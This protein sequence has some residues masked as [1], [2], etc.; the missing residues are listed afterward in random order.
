MKKKGK[1]KQNYIE[2]FG[3]RFCL[4]KGFRKMLNNNHPELKDEKL[5]SEDWSKVNKTLKKL[6][7]LKT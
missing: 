6:G 1:F 2:I 7:K 4:P 3:T 5:K